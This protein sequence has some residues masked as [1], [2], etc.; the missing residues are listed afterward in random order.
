MSIDRDRAVRLIE[1]AIPLL[2]SDNENEV[3]QASRTVQQL[4]RRHLDTDLLTCL[5]NYASGKD[6]DGKTT[7]DWKKEAARLRI[8]N[9]RLKKQLRA[10]TPQL[11]K[12]A[13]LLTYKSI[14]EG[15]IKEYFSPHVDR[16]VSTHT[17]QANF[18]NMHPQL[19]V[20]QTTAV[21]F[22]RYFREITG[23]KSVKGGEL[24]QN[25]GF[26]VGLYKALPEIKNG[27]KVRK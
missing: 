4:A 2:G 8:E 11:K 20:A 7:A 21:M 5:R 17:L 16:W 23:L 19:A 26:Q 24:R 13:P 6:E 22:S 12:G 3:S 1:K 15:W 18:E 9:N 14:L 10:L 27:K 25:K